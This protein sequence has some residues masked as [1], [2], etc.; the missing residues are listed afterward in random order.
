MPGSHSNGVYTLTNEGEI[1]FHFATDS[2]T[3]PVYCLER[4]S[5]SL[6]LR[7][8]GQLKPEKYGWPYR[9]INDGL[10]DRTTLP[11]EK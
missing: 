5:K 8:K 7:K 2:D 11:P 3:D 1:T 4:D 10:P 9:M 6:Y